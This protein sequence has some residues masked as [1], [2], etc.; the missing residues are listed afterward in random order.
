MILSTKTSWIESKKNWNHN[1]DERFDDDPFKPD[2]YVLQYCN[3]NYPKI[4]HFICQYKIIDKDID[5]GPIQNLG[6]E[7]NSMISQ[8]QPYSATK[9]HF[10]LVIGS[11]FCMT[12]PAPI[13]LQ[14]L[15]VHWTVHISLHNVY[16]SKGPVQLRHFL[17]S[18]WR[19]AY[20][21]V[22]WPSLGL[23]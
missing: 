6:Q 1:E 10:I 9:I 11:Q 4:F 23:P 15:T 20:C 13:K 5:L 3:A 14:D 18:W 16:R 21:L 8:S 19:D 2:V 22:T 7:N 12:K 17:K